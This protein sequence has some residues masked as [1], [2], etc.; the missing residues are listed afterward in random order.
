MYY[1]S[2]NIRINVQNGDNSCKKKHHFDKEELILNFEEII[3]TGREFRKE[4]SL[5]M[6]SMTT[7]LGRGTT[8]LI[9]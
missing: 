8:D 4:D 7:G 9:S 3:L 6:K 1:K 5:T 2:S